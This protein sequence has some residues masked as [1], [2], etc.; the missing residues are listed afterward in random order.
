MHTFKAKF[1]STLAGI[2]PTFPKNLRDL[3]LP[4]TELILNLLRQSTLNPKILA[5]EY[6]QVPFDFKSTPLGPL[7]CPIMIHQKTC[8]RNSWDFRGKEGCSIGVSFDHYRCQRVI[9]QGIKSKKISDTVEFCHQTITTPVV[10]PKHR[11][12]HGITRLTDYLTDAPT[13]YSD[14]QP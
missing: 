8:N 3:L 12:L 5:W 2:A 1:L 7:G 6:F 14:A 4:Q 9:P 13:A 10:T 11:I